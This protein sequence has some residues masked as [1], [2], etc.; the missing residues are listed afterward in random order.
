[1]CSTHFV[2]RNRRQ[3]REISERGELV[4]GSDSPLVYS[5]HSTAD[6][7]WRAPIRLVLKTHLAAGVQ[8]TSTKTLDR[9]PTSKQLQ[10]HADFTEDHMTTQATSHALDT[11]Q[12]ELFSLSPTLTRP[13]PERRGVMWV[14]SISRSKVNRVCQPC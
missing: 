7:V 5:A 3:R 14:V 9:L 11:N 4:R 12:H 8:K 6:D 1:M 2:R 13:C 10:F